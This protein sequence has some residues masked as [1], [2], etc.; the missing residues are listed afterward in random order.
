MRGTLEK[1]GYLSVELCI[2]PSKNNRWKTGYHIL[3]MLMFL[4][5]S[6]EQMSIIEKTDEETKQSKKELL[7]VH[8][9]DGVRCNND[10][11]NLQ[12]V[13]QGQNKSMANGHL[14]LA[15]YSNGGHLY[16]S[17]DSK[18]NAAIFF[19]IQPN[20]IEYYLNTLDTEEDKRILIEKDNI[21]YYLI[22]TK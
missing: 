19:G 10:F 11:S 1:T 3:G 13:T 14:V 7:E 12:V 2:G 6:Q 21:S 18:S 20:N 17:F 9:R 4:Q 8:H 22:K 16:K 15:L 5:P